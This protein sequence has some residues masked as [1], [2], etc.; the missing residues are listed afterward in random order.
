MGAELLF[1]CVRRTAL[2]LLLCLPFV[3]PLGAEEL[4]ASNAPSKRQFYEA[5][6]NVWQSAAR[7][8]HAESQYNLGILYEMGPTGPIYESGVI[9]PQDKIQAL[10]WFSLAADRGYEDAVMRRDRLAEKMTPEQIAE[11]E[12][13]TREWKVGTP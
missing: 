4:P 6:I 8:G 10:M 1:N 9:I 13:L 2:A 3:A 11:S 5:I 7:L 12:R